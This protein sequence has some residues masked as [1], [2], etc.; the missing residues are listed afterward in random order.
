MFVLFGHKY[1]NAKDQ[2]PLNEGAGK[3]EHKKS[4][5]GKKREGCAKI[6]TKNIKV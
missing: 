4:T 1:Q 5:N 3:E 2:K 6:K